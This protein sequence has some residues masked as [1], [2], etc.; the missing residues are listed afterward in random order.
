MSSNGYILRISISSGSISVKDIDKSLSQITETEETLDGF[1]K[2]IS[3]YL[4]KY[5]EMNNEL[6]SLTPDELVT[7]E[8]DLAKNI[9][10]KEDLQ[11][12]S[13]TFQGEIDEIDSKI[14]QLVSEIESKL[15]Q[16]SNTKY[17][18]LSS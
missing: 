16:F 15:R 5:D 4:E 10:S 14:P 13:E 3:E 2:Q 1:I 18:I 11:Y 6:I 9:S 7:L 17:T 8:H 12:K